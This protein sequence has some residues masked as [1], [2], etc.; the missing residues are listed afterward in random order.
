M[1]VNLG[2]EDFNSTLDRRA[3]ILVRNDSRF[4]ETLVRLRK[5]RGLTQEQ[6]AERMHVS[7]PA[8]ASFERIE[9]DPKLSTIRRYAMAVGLLIDHVVE[10]DEGETFQLSV[11]LNEVEELP[12]DDDVDASHYSLEFSYAS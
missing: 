9:N 2:F 5:D 12:I 11:S 10:T 7:Q 6:V 4:H 1:N 8:V 3:E